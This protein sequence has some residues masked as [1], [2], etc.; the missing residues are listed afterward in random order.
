MDRPQVKATYSMLLAVSLVLAALPA[1]AHLVSTGLGPVYDGVSHFTLTPEQI[2]PM[3]TLALLAGLRGPVHARRV[4]FLLPP[5]WLAGYLAAIASSQALPP[6]VPASALLLAGM[7]LATDAKFSPS[8]AVGMAVAFGLALGG[9]YQAS[10]DNTGLLSTVG[11]CACT[12]VILALLSAVSLSLRAHAAKI[13][14]RVS[15]SW[16]AALGL[17]MVGW[18]VRGHT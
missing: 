10:G 8:V 1:S 5:A 15:G 16:T 7:L 3:V 14:I 17:L 6:L 11:A 13:A 4:L 12:F 18:W 9:A 2:L